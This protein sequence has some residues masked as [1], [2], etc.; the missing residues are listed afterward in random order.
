MLETGTPA[1]DLAPVAPDA[2]AMSWSSVH[3]IQPGPDTYARL[4]DCRSAVELRGWLLSFA[5]ELGFY[6]ARYVHYGHLLNGSQDRE[7][8]RPLRWLSTAVREQDA[9]EHAWLFADPIISFMRTAFEPLTW[10]TNVTPDMS[11]AQR[12]WLQS[13]RARGV[14][15][16]IA[17]PIQD[18]ACG[19]AY[20]SLFGVDEDA[21]DGLLRRSAPQLAFTAARFHALA[22]SLVE[23]SA[24]RQGRALLTER[25]I[26]CLRLAALG[27]TVAES[28]R[29]LSIA[30]RT[31]EFH[32]KN[33]AEKL[34][35]R[36]KLRAV[37]L[38]VGT[39][40][41]HV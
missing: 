36:S 34:G 5:R 30:V 21:A 16:G 25:E 35:A 39:G 41:I 31:V 17:I 28:G 22:K 13:E 11:P 26:E 19:P 38:A 6:G 40:L 2:P 29:T 37:A 27:C 12:D 8:H 33:A 24:G 10:S 4:G 18:Y 7:D 20:L 14:G 9:G 32:L 1:R 3:G 15:A 23:G